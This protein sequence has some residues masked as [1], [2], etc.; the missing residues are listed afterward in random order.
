[1]ERV[2]GK[3]RVSDCI[4]TQIRKRR[5]AFAAA[6][7]AGA[8]WGV[9]FLAPRALLGSDSS[10][11]ALFRFLF[12]GV[13]ASGALFFR[14]KKLPK[15]RI[16]DFAWGMGLALLG[17]SFY[18]YLLS[19]GVKNAGVTYATLIIGMLPLT[20]VLCVMPR[21]DFRHLTFPFVMIFCGAVLLALRD[22]ALPPT[23]GAGLLAAF[24]ALGC[25]TAFSILNAR[26]LKR[27]RE[28]AVFDWSS[29]LG[30]FSALTAFLIFAID[31]PGA[32]FETMGAALS[33]R[34]LLWTGFMGIG[35]AWFATGLWNYASR[36]L[37]SALV[38]QLLVSET[39]FGLFF[40]LIYEGRVP[41]FLESAAIFLLLAG[42]LLGI[43]A[44][45]R[46]MGMMKGSEN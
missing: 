26:F 12:F 8:I 21:F 27:R 20:I 43:R 17:F 9:S 29:W 18:Y 19:F 40:G 39:I 11:L 33:P 45:N 31:H 34:L 5:L 13:L 15:I 23:H 44:V 7:L 10:T 28:W 4:L 35:G 37:P 2:K 32:V 22:A 16:G 25:W 24:S 38:A 30:I 6:I 41:S 36:V 1:M 14:R 42:A 46:I 3:P